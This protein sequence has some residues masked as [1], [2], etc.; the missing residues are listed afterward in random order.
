MTCPQCSSEM[1][2]RQRGGVTVAQCTSCEGLF[3]ARIDLGILIEQENDWH[4]SSGP[5]TQPIPRIVPGMTPPHD[6]AATKQ[7]RSYLDELFG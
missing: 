4:V 6:Y 7:A 2:E 3:L 1:V 5:G